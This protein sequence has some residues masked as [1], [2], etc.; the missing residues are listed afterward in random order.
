MPD[1]AAPVSQWITVAKGKCQ[2]SPEEAAY[3]KSRPITDVEV[4]LLKAET[5]FKSL[6][7]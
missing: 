4:A 3:W 6:K 5:E 1:A 7:P 2:I